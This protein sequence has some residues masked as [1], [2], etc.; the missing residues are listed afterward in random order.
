VVASQA[1]ARA[2]W[3]GLGRHTE[4]AKTRAMK[5]RI[6]VLLSV[7][8]A[9]LVLW[10]VAWFVG[11]GYLR[12]AVVA[13]AE[14]DGV[15]A[16]RVECGGL[17][18]GGYPFR[19]DLTCR[20]GRIL[21]GDL[22]LTVP[23]IRASA[24][25]YAP[26]HVLASA[27]GPLG[28]SDSFTG[29]RNSLQWTTLDGSVRLD[30]WRIARLS[31]ESTDLVWSDTLVGDA[32]LAQ[33]P[34]AELHLLDIP[35]QHDAERHLAALAGYARVEN[36]ANPGMTLS[37]ATLE[38]ETELTGLPDDVRN[39]GEPELLRLMQGWG[40]Q[41]R[42]VRLHGTDGASTLEASGTLGL[43]PQGLLEGTIDIASTGVAERIGPLIEEPWRTLV[44]G[45]P[46]ADGSYSNQLN[47]RAGNLSSGLFPITAVPP[48][49]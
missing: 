36:M 28:L 37:N 8:V 6:I 10:T 23:A 19:Y 32:V 17:D 5:K 22:V 21:T 3:Q 40:S 29:A 30:S 18:I 33:V 35:E 34:R 39:W 16:P 14:A 46:G 15:T 42:I 41:L 24:R 13:Q 31:L 1:W 26:F 11:A 44:L 43:D 20:D 45:T 47:F 27:D 7:I 12:G 49:F 9:V 2:L 48:L 25:V 38:L 4:G